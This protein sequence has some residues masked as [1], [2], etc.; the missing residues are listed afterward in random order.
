MHRTMKAQ[1]SSPAAATKA[2]QQRRFDDFRRHYNRER[3]HE[4]LDQTPPSAHW[5]PSLRAL[6]TGIEE[7]WYDADHEVRR[8]GER[9][10]SS[11]GAKSSSSAKP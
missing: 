3:P 8:V 1:T 6:P 10:A 9:A 5:Q 7:P 11:G 2:E 4:A